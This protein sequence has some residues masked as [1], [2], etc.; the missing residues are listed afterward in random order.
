MILETLQVQ[1]DEFEETRSVLV[2]QQFETTFLSMLKILTDTK[3]RL[4]ITERPTSLAAVKLPTLESFTLSLK[5]EILSV[6]RI[7]GDAPTPFHQFFMNKDLKVN[8]STLKYTKAL[9]EEA[10]VRTAYRY[11]N[12]LDHYFRL[13]DGIID[14]IFKGPVI[15][16]E[17]YVDIL[18]TQFSVHEMTIIFYMGIANFKSHNARDI[19]INKKFDRLNLFKNL[20]FTSIIHRSDTAFYPTT[21]FNFLS[22]AESKYRDRLIKEGL[23][24]DE[25]FENVPKYKSAV[26]FLKDSMRDGSSH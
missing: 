9:I 6:L 23:V 1:K 2:I 3:E 4:A 25:V 26:D 17:K 11:N 8:K 19:H 12:S 14:F 21:T 13:I 16:K 15:D 24:D 20:S 10:F 5:D 18:L 22:D 7:S